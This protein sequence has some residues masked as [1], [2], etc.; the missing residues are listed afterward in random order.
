MYMFH[1]TVYAH[2]LHIITSPDGNDN[3]DHTH[4]RAK[5]PTTLASEVSSVEEGG[6]MIKVDY[7]S[8]TPVNSCSKAGFFAFSG[9]CYI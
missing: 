5:V 1:I 6:V 9:H 8:L 3:D 2:V 4:S 7:K